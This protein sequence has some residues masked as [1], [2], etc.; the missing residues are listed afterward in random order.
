[1]PPK[2]GRGNPGTPRPTAGRPPSPYIERRGEIAVKVSPA[3]RAAIELIAM[4]RQI[5]PIALIA[6]LVEAARLEEL[7]EK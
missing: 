1:M 2:R 5:S 3:T 4:R 7:Q 6:A